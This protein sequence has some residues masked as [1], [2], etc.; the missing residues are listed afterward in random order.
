MNTSGGVRD[1]FS[2]MQRQ[3]VCSRIA[4]PYYPELGEFRENEV[5]EAQRWLSQPWRLPRLYGAIT[6]TSEDNRP[7]LGVCG[8][9][10]I[11]CGWTPVGPD[12]TASL[13][14][15]EE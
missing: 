13:S 9:S 12:A 3:V 10:L 5:A 6:A 14:D 2:R 7:A 8:R 1:L 11:H 4:I 15:G